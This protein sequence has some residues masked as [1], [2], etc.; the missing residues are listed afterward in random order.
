MNSRTTWL[1]KF[2][3][4]ILTSFLISTSLLAG[5]Y[6]WNGGTSTAWGTS[7]NWTPNGTPSTN[8]TVTIV[9][10]SNNVYIAAKTE[11]KLLTMTSGTLNLQ[12][13][14]LSVGAN[15]FFNGGTVTNGLLTLIGTNHTFAGSTISTKVSARCTRVFL[16]GSVFNDSLKIVIP[17]TGRVHASKGGN[18]FNGPVSITDSAIAGITLADSLPDIFNS[19]LDLYNASTANIFIAHKATG[20]Q[21]NGTVSFNG[22]NIYSN[23]YGSATYTSNIILN[24]ASGNFFFGYSTGSCTQTAGNKISIGG[25][26]MSSG[27]LYLRNFTSLDSSSKITLNMTGTAK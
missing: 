16:N 5:N 1:N 12:S 13:N 6:T 21:F 25:S 24:N 22:P 19:T 26:G 9:T 20:C 7:T 23:Y 27:Q 17:S 15:S 18:T 14:E 8:D 3:L 2:I 4:T 10:G 11:V